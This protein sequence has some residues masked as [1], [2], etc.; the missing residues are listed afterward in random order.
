MKT[1]KIKPEYIDLWQGSEQTPD[2]DMIITEEEVSRLSE[3]WET[4]V[5]D[6]LEQLIEQ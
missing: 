2:S 4:P 6:L 5:E 3:E 1:Y